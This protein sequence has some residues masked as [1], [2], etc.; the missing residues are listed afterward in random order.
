DKYKAAGREIAQ[1]IGCY[2]HRKASLLLGGIWLPRLARRDMPYGRDMPF[3]RDMC[4]WHAIC[5]LWRREGP[6]YTHERSECISR[7][8]K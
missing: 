2:G 7:R 1:L 4:L 8:T 6:R 5:R 3:R